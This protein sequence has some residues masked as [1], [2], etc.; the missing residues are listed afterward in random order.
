MAQQS[1]L[2]RAEWPRWGWSRVRLPAGCSP[3]ARSRLWV[4][5]GAE[6][7][8]EPALSLS[9]I[10]HINLHSVSNHWLGE[11]AEGET[12]SFALSYFCLATFFQQSSF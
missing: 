8:A 4:G 2:G 1:V 5:E 9:N 11:G 7:R 10:P 6:S 3:W 12:G